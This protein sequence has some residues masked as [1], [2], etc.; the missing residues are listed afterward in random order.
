[1]IFIIKRRVLGLIWLR[2]LQTKAWLLLQVKSIDFSK[3]VARL[4]LRLNS[5]GLT[6]EWRAHSW[7]S[8]MEVGTL[9]RGLSSRP[10]W[11]NGG[12][13]NWIENTEYWLTRTHCWPVWGVLMSLWS[14]WAKRRGTRLLVLVTAHNSGL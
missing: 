2:V 13:T 10:V 8:S 3:G 7:G 12:L 11:D 6:A 4:E 14:W 1:M 5:S 9:V